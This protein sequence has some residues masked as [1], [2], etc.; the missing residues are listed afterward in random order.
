M[1]CRYSTILDLWKGSTRANIL[2]CATA[3]FCSPADR[4]SNSRPEYANPSARSSSVNIPILLQMASAV[5]LLSPVIMIT[6]MPALRQVSMAGFTSILGGS[7]MPT[8]PTKVRFCSYLANLVESFKSMS[9]GVIG[10]FSLPNLK[11]VHRSSTPSVA[12]F[13]NILGASPS[14]VGFF[15]VQKL[16][17]DLRSRENSRV[18]SFFHLDSMSLR[19][20]LADSRRPPDLAIPYGFTFSAR[21]IRAVS[22]ASP[23][24]SKM[25][26]NSLKSMAESLHMMAIVEI[27]S[28]TTKSLPL[29]LRPLWKM[30]PMGSYVDPDTSNSSKLDSS[31]N[32]NILQMDI[33]LV[34]RVPVL[35]EQMTEVQPRVSTDGKDRTMA[36]FAAILR[37]PRARQVVM[38]AGR[39]SGMAAT[40]K[41]TAIL[42]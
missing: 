20:T 38:T 28:R 42:K 22:V 11:W 3:L 10:F 25:F 31:L 17:M 8:T 12:P 1:D 29:T 34:V 32:V 2:D 30:S 14:R 15:G 35:S 18:K 39:P 21:V 7:N 41:A 36:F 16:D 33:M 13:T 40:A 23:T 26:L 24:F 27:S 19:T 9:L 5:F 6:R 4:S 37:V